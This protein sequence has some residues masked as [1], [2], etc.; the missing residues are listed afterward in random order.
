MR[1]PL[2]VVLVDVLTAASSVSILAVLVSFDAQ[3]AKNVKPA[4]RIASFCIVLLVV[5][6]GAALPK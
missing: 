1:V 2:E 3:P 6:S 5:R 4:I